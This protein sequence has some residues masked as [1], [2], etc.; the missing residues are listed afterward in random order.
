MTSRREFLAVA[1]AMGVLPANVS[2]DPE[3]PEL[4]GLL[5]STDSGVFDYRLGVNGSD[6]QISQFNKDTAL[7]IATHPSDPNDC[8]TLSIRADWGEVGVFL[9]AEE[10]RALASALERAADQWKGDQ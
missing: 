6:L 7:H 3:R 1:A 9:T 2:A 5:E 10:A 4:H 8:A